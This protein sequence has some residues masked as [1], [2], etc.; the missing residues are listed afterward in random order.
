MCPSRFRLNK[1]LLAKNH[2]QSVRVL[3]SEGGQI[4]SE[5]QSATVQARRVLDNERAEA[6]LVGLAQI[7]ALEH[8]VF[9]LREVSHDVSG[10]CHSV[11][12]Q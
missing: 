11:M 5:E 10:G 9:V 1:F 8:I 3:C 6:L 12:P 7:R 2:L 4:L